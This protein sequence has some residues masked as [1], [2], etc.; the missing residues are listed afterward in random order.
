MLR[1]V[2]LSTKM[3]KREKRACAQN[4]VMYKKQAGKRSERDKA[5]ALFCPHK[6]PGLQG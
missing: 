3:A 4:K 2:D 6:L 1:K 5:L